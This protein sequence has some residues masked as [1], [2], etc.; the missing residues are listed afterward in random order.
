MLLVLGEYETELD[1]KEANSMKEAFQ[2]AKLIKDTNTLS[3]N[4]AFLRE[5]ID[6]VLRR[7][8]NEILPLQPITM[9]RLDDAIVRTEQLLQSAILSNSMPLSGLPPCIATE[10]FNERGEELQREWIERKDRQL[11]SMLGNFPDGLDGPP[12]KADILKATK[13]K[14]V[15]WNP[16]TVL[17]RSNRQSE[18]SYKEQQL[19]LRL[20]VNAVNTYSHVFGNQNVPRGVLTNGA[21]GAGKTFVLQAQ[22]LYGMSMRLR[23]MSTSLMALSLDRHHQKTKFLR[24]LLT[25]EM[26][27]LDECGQ[28]SAQQLA[29]M[30]IILRP[31]RSSALPFEGVLICGSF[32]HA[33]L[34]SIG[35]LPFLI[36]SHILSD[37]TLVR[38][39]HSVRASTDLALQEI[40][41][42]TRTSQFVLQEDDEIRDRFYYLMNKHIAFVE[43]WEDERIAPNTQRMYHR[44]KTAN[45][46]MLEFI[47]LFQSTKNTLEYSQSQLMIMAHVPTKEQTDNWTDITL[48]A[49]PPGRESPQ[50]LFL[51]EPPTEDD[52]L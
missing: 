10:L 16:L 36:S 46:T 26:L 31:A 49:S 45:D 2:V 1:F 29:L 35:G 23:V 8:I 11:N 42:I 4:E 34:G 20:G 17:K 38:L 5:Q 41:Q 48:F 7:V 40:Q 28:L 37:F 51:F 43:S 33:Q 19:A 39:E 30:D 18:E 12:S 27:L 24:I 21:P 44:R 52:L 47:P 3:D 9:R 15:V 6:I 22:G 14:P 32:D 25:M 50:Q 13:V